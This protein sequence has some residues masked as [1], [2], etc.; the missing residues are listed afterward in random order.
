MHS[1]RFLL[2]ELFGGSISVHSHEAHRNY[3][4]K[5]LFSNFVEAWLWIGCVPVIG[6][7]SNPWACTVNW[8]GH[9]H[10]GLFFPTLF[11]P[12]LLL[13]SSNPWLSSFHAIIGSQFLL[14]WLQQYAW[15]RDKHLLAPNPDSEYMGASNSCFSFSYNHI[16][17]PMLAS[18]KIFFSV[19]LF[20]SEGYPSYMPHDQTLQ[21]GC[22]WCSLVAVLKQAAI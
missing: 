5:V 22:H 1:G 3:K 11:F 16:W 2:I 18:N 9:A 21:Q 12:K 19:V 14:I 17:L 6:P 4:L 8:E 15:N 7:C 20:F 13:F 10:R